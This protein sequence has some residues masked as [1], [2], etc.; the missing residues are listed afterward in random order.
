MNT[1]ESWNVQ[2]PKGGGL[3]A[4]SATRVKLTP[5]TALFEPGTTFELRMGDA[6]GGDALEVSALSSSEHF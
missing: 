1:V 5:R 6:D 3:S 2:T 4:D